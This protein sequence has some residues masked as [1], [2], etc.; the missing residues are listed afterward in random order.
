MLK[1]FAPWLLLESLWSPLAAAASP[2]NGADLIVYGDYLLTMDPAQ[3]E[4]RDA[5]VVVRD[6]VIVDVGPLE[7]IDRAWVAKASIAGEGAC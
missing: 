2:A 5:A 6:S 1:L 7:R 3:P 4:L